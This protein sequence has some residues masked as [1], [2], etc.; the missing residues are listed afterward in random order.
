MNI[1]VRFAVAFVVPGMFLGCR[2]SIAAP[3]G[4]QG[5]DLRSIIIEQI[6]THVRES[7]GEFAGENFSD[8]DLRDF[9][10]RKVPSQI[11]TDLKTN[12]L[13][14]N[15]VEK[16]RAKAPGERA[17]YLKK[18]QQP[19]RPTWAEQGRIDRNGTTDAGRQAELE[20]AGA[21]TDYAE[22][23]LASSANTTGR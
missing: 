23:L 16:V 18:C 5:T 3:G 17:E 8:E 12:N 1:A 21:I 9:E 2:G 10:A 4:S 19:W 22:S 6:R 11:V 15:A 7:Y 20:I 14:L 13:F